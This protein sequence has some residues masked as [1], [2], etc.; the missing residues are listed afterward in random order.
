MAKTEDFFWTYEQACQEIKKVAGKQ[1]DVEL[2]MIAKDILVNHSIS[3]LLLDKVITLIV[4]KFGFTRTAVKKFLRA[5]IKKK[6]EGDDEEATHAEI[7]EDFVAEKI[8]EDAV[9]SE[10]SLWIYDDDNGVYEKKDMREVRIQVGNEYPSSNC[11]TG[12]H[13]KN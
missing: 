9:G 7:A 8:P 4:H 5:E 10:G 13:Y 12:G 3:D 6:T 11:K 2:E 1:S